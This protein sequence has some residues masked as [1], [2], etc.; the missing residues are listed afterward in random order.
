MHR[1]VLLRLEVREAGKLCRCKRNRKHLIHKGQPRLVVQAP[2]AG[3]P[4]HGYCA[5]CAEQMLSQAEVKLADLHTDL[6]G[7]AS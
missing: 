5:D 1:S 2:G 7:S 3:T 6:E 4:E